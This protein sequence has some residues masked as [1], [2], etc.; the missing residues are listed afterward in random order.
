MMENPSDFL[1]EKQTIFKL[2]QEVYCT[3]DDPLTCKLHW[4]SSSLYL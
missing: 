1:L 4:F 3:H 2:C